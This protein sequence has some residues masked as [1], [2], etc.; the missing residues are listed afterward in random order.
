MKKPFKGIVVVRAGPEEI[1]LPLLQN[2]Q[3]A[4]TFRPGVP[5]KDEK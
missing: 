3:R 5:K 4:V 2:D 1:Q